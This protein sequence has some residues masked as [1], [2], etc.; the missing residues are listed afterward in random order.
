MLND[1]CLVFYQNFWI[2]YMKLVHFCPQMWTLRLDYSCLPKITQLLNN[3]TKMQTQGDLITTLYHLLRHSTV[4]LQM[5]LDTQKHTAEYQLSEAKRPAICCLCIQK[6]ANDNA[7]LRVLFEKYLLNCIHKW[8]LFSLMMYHLTL[9]RNQVW[10]H[11]ILV[12][13]IMLFEQEQDGIMN[14]RFQSIKH[15]ATATV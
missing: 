11:E 1:F 8:K 13:K 3:R 6:S 9:L 5:F 12:I 7:T 10:F 2:N 15:R 14:N 4:L